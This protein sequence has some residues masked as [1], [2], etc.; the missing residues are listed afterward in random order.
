MEETIETHPVCR[1][2]LVLGE[3]GD[4]QCVTKK[5]PDGRSLTM[6]LVNGEIVEKHMT[7]KVLWDLEA[8]K[9]ERDDGA[10]GVSFKHWDLRGLAVLKSYYDTYLVGLMF[11][12]DYSRVTHP[13]IKCEKVEDELEYDIDFPTVNV[14]KLTMEDGYSSLQKENLN[15]GSIMHRRIVDALTRL[16]KNESSEDGAEL[17]VRKRK[18]EED[19]PQCDACVEKPCVW[20]SER[21][22]VIA[23][24]K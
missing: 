18:A 22:T 23:K 8:I 4:K 15:L 13:K 17:V 20:I 1:V 5:Y 6:S 21:D 9:K 3:N 14:G 19:V 11:T 2:D 24:T 10:D 16:K 12:L 7:Y